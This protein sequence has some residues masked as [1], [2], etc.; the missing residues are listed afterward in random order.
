MAIIWV[1]FMVFVIVGLIGIEQKQK[2]RLKND[3]RIITRLD[4]IIKEINSKKQEEQQ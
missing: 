4:L 1:V 2:A 3:E